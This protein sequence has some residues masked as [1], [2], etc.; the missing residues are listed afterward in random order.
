MRLVPILFLLPALI[1][2][3]SS[4]PA[5][6]STLSYRGFFLAAPYADF[7]A[8][9]RTLALPGAGGSVVV[10]NT[11]RRTAQLMECGLSIRD[12][13]DSAE[14]YLAAY[15]LEGT[16]AFL[17]FGDSGSAPLVESA[18]RELVARFGAPRGSRAGMWEWGTATEHVR[19]TWRG[20]GDARWIYIALWDDTVMNRIAHYAHRRAP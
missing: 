15:V 17:S 9:A 5:P 2:A 13:V 16:V 19:L 4:P 20:R 8:R 11:S 10:C 1:G 14:L 12:P 7:L 18:R 3:Q 6:D